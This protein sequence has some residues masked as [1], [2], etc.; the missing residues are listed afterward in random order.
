MK[1]FG[2]LTGIH[3]EMENRKDTKTQ[4]G[5]FEVVFV[6]DEINRGGVSGHVALP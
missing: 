5:I 4:M 3:A 6:P 1:V 2:V